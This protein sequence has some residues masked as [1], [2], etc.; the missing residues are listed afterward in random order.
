MPPETHDVLTLNAFDGRGGGRLDSAT[1]ALL[2]RRT[3]NFG[4]ASVLFYRAPLNL[5]RAEGVWVHTAD[6]RRYLDAYN[7]VPS[8]GHS[9]PRVAKAIAEQSGR[10]SV[11]TRYLQEVIER[12]AERLKAT[13]PKSLSNIVLVCSGS[14]A[15]DLALRLAR[16]A[17]SGVGFIVSEAAY[18]GNTAAVAEISPAALKRGGVPKHVRTVPAPCRQAYGND[19]AG[20]FA[21]AV[22]SAA[23]ALKKSGVPLAGLICD[24]IFSSDGIHAE[25]CGL[26]APAVKAAR[27]AG[28]VFIADEVQ[29]G[30]ARTGEHMWGFG[31]HGLTPDIVTMG[32]PMG[33]GFPMAGV[34]TRP[35]ILTKFC[36]ATGYFNTFGGSPVAAAAGLAVLDVIADEDLQGNALRVGDALRERLAELAQRDGRIAAVRGAGLFLGVEF[37]RAGDLNQ[38]DPKTA[39]CVINGMR[40]GGVLIGAAGRHANVLKIRPPLCLTSAHADLLVTALAATLAA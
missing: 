24:T 36:A 15:N 1:R 38:P 13:L 12:Y 35:G 28:G 34:A 32:K 39:S 6:G 17:T 21:A 40:D 37:C 25:P 16:Q 22:A 14:E 5:V 9:H 30:F 3:R 26:L 8:V 31:R 2:A 29:P 23:A 20:G 11:S 27:A 4:A 19:I 18:H 7:N 10:V 33:N